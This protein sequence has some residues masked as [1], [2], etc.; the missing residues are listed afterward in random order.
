MF[1]SQ[2]AYA[3]E[4][5]QRAGMQDCKPITTPVDIKSKLSQEGGDKITDSTL[6]RSL[7]GA[8]QYLTLTRPDIQYA[9]HQLCL[10][11]H[12]PLVTHLT[13]LKRVLRYLQGTLSHGLQLHKSSSNV[14]TAYTD[15]D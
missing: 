1:L 5:L 10:F 4:I 8:L 15:A 7:A 9:V 12:D 3:K 14:P 13:A 11:M 2:S 6:Y